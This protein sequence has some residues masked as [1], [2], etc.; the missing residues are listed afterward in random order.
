MISAQGLL[1]GTAKG[2][3]I[4]ITSQKYLSSKTAG[5]P[6]LQPRQIS[7][8]DSVIP[9]ILAECLLCL[10]LFQVNEGKDL[11]SKGGASLPRKQVVSKRPR[12]GGLVWPGGWDGG[13]EP[14][15]PFCILT[16]AQMMGPF[17]PGH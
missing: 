5:E 12:P 6:I 2:F 7:A 8:G 11:C 16:I 4:A 3:S 1:N 10:V 17:F 9:Q 15:T 13:A 14:G